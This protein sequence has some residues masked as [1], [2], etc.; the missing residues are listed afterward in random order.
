MLTT[1]ARP[2]SYEVLSPLPKKALAD[3]KKKVVGTAP[4]ATAAEEGADAPALI[5]PPAPAGSD[6]PDQVPR[7]QPTTEKHA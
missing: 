7:A 1:I 6:N 2:V 3:A 4:A 5:A